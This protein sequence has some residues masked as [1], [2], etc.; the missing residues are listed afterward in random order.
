[1]MIT[2][3]LIYFGVLF[4]LLTVGFRALLSFHLIFDNVVPHTITYGIVALVL[5]LYFG[6]KDKNEL[7][8][9]DVG[10]RFHCA[11]FLIFFMISI[12][13]RSLGFGLE[14]D[15]L[16]GAKVWGIFLSI[17]FVIYMILRSRGIKGLSREDIF[18]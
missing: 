12:I 17:H 16:A 6:F 9:F 15:I 11:T 1:M 14:L 10:F 8:I 4:A 13:L 5:G 7:P 3:N 18:E 2:K